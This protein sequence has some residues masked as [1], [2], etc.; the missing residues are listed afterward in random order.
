VIREVKYTV[1][2]NRSAYKILAIG[3]KG[4]SALVRPFPDVLI[5]SLS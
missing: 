1:A 4:T 2:A 3:E 5:G